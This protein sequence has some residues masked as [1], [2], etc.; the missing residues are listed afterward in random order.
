MKTKTIVTPKFTKS[1][2]KIITEISAITD[3]DEVR[4]E[5]IEKLLQDEL[6]AYYAELEDYY[7][8]ISSARNEAYYEGHSDGY[9]RGY[10]VGRD[11][12][13]DKGLKEGYTDGQDYGHSEGYS[14]GYSEGYSAGHSEGYYDGRYP[15]C[16]R[17]RQP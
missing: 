1:I 5:V 8:A 4:A 11:E 6:R 2:E 15:V 13:R 12:G 10:D 3:I 7:I 14:A 17:P 16:Q 9:A